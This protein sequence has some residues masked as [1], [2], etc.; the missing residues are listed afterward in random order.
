[1]G[2]S[3]LRAA[4]LVAVGVL[5]LWACDARALPA[6]ARKY[7]T[8][9]QTCHVV[10]P[11]LTPFGEAFR[12]N[13]YR[14]PGVDADV[15]KQPAIPMG[16]EAAQK[17]FPKTSWP[18]W[19]MNSVPLAVGF[20][21]SA[22]THPTDS[23]AARADN[24]TG[25]ALQDLV[26]EGHLWAGGSFTE[27]TTFFAELT[28]SPDGA[29]VERATVL[30][31]DLFF[32]DHALDLWVGREFAT[33]TSF[34][35]HSTYLGDTLIA[36]LNVAGLFGATT[37]TWNVVDAM[38]S[39]QLAGTLFGRLDYG[40]GLS[41]GVHGDVRPAEDWFAHLGY[42]LGGMRLDGEGGGIENPLRPWEES[43]VALDV[44]V[45]HSGS[46]FNNAGG[47]L[48]YDSALAYGAQ[49]RAQWRSLELD[50]GVYQESHT[51]AMADGTGATALAQYGE[52]SY[53]VFPW[54]VPAIRFEYSGLNG[55]GL[56]PNDWR[57]IP[58]VAAAVFPNLKL[59]LRAQF[60]LAL[61]T[62]P[63]AGW[64]PAGGFA[65]PGSDTT[66]LG[67]LENITLGMAYAF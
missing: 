10:Y 5:S 60:E 27:H 58:G 16:Q 44:W 46:T 52:L 45:Y 12:R 29:E 63:G 43:A 3:W 19:I 26:E 28:V 38:N 15:T 42:K 22:T 39:V 25:L 17:T 6:F 11:K 48:Q 59:V 21:G 14:F 35:P 56:T 33:L 54:L 4:S 50:Y 23:S 13:G 67:E 66:V 34:G 2:R 49:V 1:M 64:G 55:G 36:P 8:S 62:A 37:D 24:G 9:C 31:N 40:L 53:V 47:D 20:N 61:G 51:H 32:R 57:L 7:E 18:D 65:A 30:F 41:A